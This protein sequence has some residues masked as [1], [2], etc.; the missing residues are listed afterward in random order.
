MATTSVQFFFDPA[1]PWTWM[2][3][4]WLTEVAQSRDDVDVRWRP[5]SLK[6]KN[7][8]NGLPEPYS[9][10]ADATHRALRVMEAVR[11]GEGDGAVG[12]YYTELG[13]RIHH[14]GDNPLTDL[15]GAV[16]ACD[17]DP[18]YLDAADDD[19]WDAAIRASMAE[20]LGAAGEDVGSP[21]LMLRTD[22]PTAFF[23]PIVSPPPTGQA[24]LDLWDRLSGMADQP[25]FFELK[26][27]RTEGPQLGPRP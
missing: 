11:E 22:P 1:C 23:G 26:R 7:E 14:D 2:T 16:A 27:S 4:R 13:R 21:I 15:A 10:R 24:A 17:L 6:F 19:E 5:F 20:A 9:S 18:S 8:E 25:S 3:S 12:P